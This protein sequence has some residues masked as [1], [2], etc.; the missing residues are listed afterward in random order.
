[1]WF[2]FTIDHNCLHEKATLFGI[3]GKS[4]QFQCKSWMMGFGTLHDF[5]SNFYRL[6]FQPNVIVQY[7]KKIWWGMSDLH[8]YS[9]CT[10]WNLLTKILESRCSDWIQPEAKEYSNN[11]TPTQ[12]VM[13]DLKFK[14]FQERKKMKKYK[15]EIISKDYIKLVNGHQSLLSSWVAF[16]VSIYQVYKEF[17]VI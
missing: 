6:I 8:N 2:I 3:P 15:K 13:N 17:I 7:W 1:M 16:C 11:E 14:L 9:L 10:D 4:Q 5:L 12:M